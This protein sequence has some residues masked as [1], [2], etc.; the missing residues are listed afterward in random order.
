MCPGKR[1]EQRIPWCACRPKFK[2]Y[3]IEV[4]Q[5]L[6]HWVS[7]YLISSIG[8]MH[9]TNERMAKVLESVIMQRRVRI[10]DKCIKEMRTRNHK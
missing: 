5:Q 10:E 1:K 7:P 4:S 2:V 8:E 3:T 9:E 6:P